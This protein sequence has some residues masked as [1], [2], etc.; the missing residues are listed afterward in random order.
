VD[1]PYFFLKYLFTSYISTEFGIP[2]PPLIKKKKNLMINEACQL[3]KYAH[4]LII[5]YFYMTKSQH[6]NK[7]YSLK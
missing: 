7:N 5:L 1:F 3:N 4:K 2:H 6:T